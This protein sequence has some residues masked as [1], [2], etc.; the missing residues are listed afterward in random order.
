M[1]TEFDYPAWII[2]VFGI[3]SLSAGIGEF[4]KAGFWASMIDDLEKIP[5]LRFLTGVICIGIG[6]PLYL[7]APWS[8]DWML[9]AVKVIGGWMVVEGALFLAIGDM[10]MNFARKLMGGASRLWASIAIL[11]GLAVIA[12]AGIRI[13]AGL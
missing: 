7:I 12:A 10:F 9:V 3:Y 2:L 6:T 5:A 1:V 11:A 13:S 8:G 4:R